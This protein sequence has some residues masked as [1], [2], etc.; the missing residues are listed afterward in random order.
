VLFRSGLHKMLGK[1]DL[2][3]CVIMSNLDTENQR[4][5]VEAFRKYCKELADKGAKAEVIDVRDDNGAMD[6]AKTYD[7]AAA[8]LKAHPQTNILICTEG[9][10]AYMI[11]K[12]VAD[13]GLKG[14]V[15]VSGYDDQPR[16]LDAVKNGT[17]YSLMVQNFFNWGY[18]PTKNLAKA[19][20][21]GEKFPSFINAG[22]IEV[23]KANIDTYA[24]DLEKMH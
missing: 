6:D 23:T 15:L 7:T 14:K 10:G 3:V 11:G 8:M 17:V 12:A 16:C 19:I 22:V 21:N 18:L 1:D 20:V 9:A 2:Q 5:Q 4:I 24:A 13:A